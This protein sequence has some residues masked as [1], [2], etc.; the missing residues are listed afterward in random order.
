[1]GTMPNEQTTYALQLGFNYVV[2]LVEIRSVRV[3]LPW[4][5]IRPRSRRYVGPTSHRTPA[6]VV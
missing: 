4:R 6:L 3:D 1:M 5:A 2:N